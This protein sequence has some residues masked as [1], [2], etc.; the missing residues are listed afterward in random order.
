MKKI[1]EEQ[2]AETSPEN[3]FEKN[4]IKNYRIAEQKFAYLKIKVRR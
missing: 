2:K 3:I 1:Y 4:E